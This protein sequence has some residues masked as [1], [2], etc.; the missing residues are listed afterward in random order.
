V[1]ACT[2]FI[3]SDGAFDIHYVDAAGHELSAD[4]TL[5]SK[6]KAPAKKAPAKN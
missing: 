4:E 5:K 2:L 1:T 3:V 6:P